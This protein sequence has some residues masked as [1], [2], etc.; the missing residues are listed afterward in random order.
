MTRQGRPPIVVELIIPPDQEDAVDEAIGAWLTVL[1]NDAD[2]AGA[3]VT[4]ED[5][6]PIVD[7]CVACGVTFP[8]APD[9]R[10]AD[11]SVCPT[12]KAL[13]PCAHPEHRLSSGPARD[14]K[15]GRILGA[16]EASCLTCGATVRRGR[17]RGRS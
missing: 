14:T 7:V 17:K 15:T 1:M 9:D 4:A 13:P 6:D 16:E 3:V 5:E 12:C 2:A 10:P 11:G 8:I